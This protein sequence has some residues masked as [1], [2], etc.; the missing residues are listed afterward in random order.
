MNKPVSP[1]LALYEVAQHCF[2]IGGALAPASIR[3]QLTRAML[4]TDELW[5]HGLID[6]ESRPL[7]VI[8]GGAAGVAAAIRSAQRGVHVT[9][10]EQS[11]SYFVRQRNGPTR[12]LSPT[13]YDWPQQHWNDTSWITD[14]DLLPLPYIEGRADAIFEAWQV[15]LDRLPVPVYARIIEYQS[16][17]ARRLWIQNDRVYLALAR[18]EGTIGPF[19]AALLALGPGEERTTL[20]FTKK[21]RVPRS[22]TPGFRG[23]GFWEKMDLSPNGNAVV[24]SGGG[25]GGIQDLL[26]HATSTPNPRELFL[27]LRYESARSLETQ[28]ERDALNTAWRDIEAKLL[29]AEINAGRLRKQSLNE[30]DDK[31][32][33]HDLDDNYAEALDSFLTEPATRVVLAE[34]RRVLVPGVSITLIHPNS[35]F[36]WCYPLNRFLA[37]LLRYLVKTHGEDVPTVHFTPEVR[38]ERVSSA[39]DVENKLHACNYSPSACDKFPHDVYLKNAPSDQKPLRANRVILRHGSI[40]SPEVLHL[41]TPSPFYEQLPSHYPYTAPP[42]IDP[43]E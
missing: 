22:P 12:W 36:S 23:F 30:E 9:L 8:G 14:L 43:I 3:D 11:D 41:S 5:V 15:K 27:L 40:A 37:H 32:V 17:L 25:D 19:G 4:C 21:G 38:V 18:G 31:K 2:Y 16:C 28:E 1:H 10:V 13:L 29:V 20:E 35:Y 33:L 7:V 6:T 39:K 34:F 26:L 42:V 24:I